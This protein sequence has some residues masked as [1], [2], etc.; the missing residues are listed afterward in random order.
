MPRVPRPP[1]FSL[2]WTTPP[3]LLRLLSGFLVACIWIAAPGGVFGF[4]LGAASKGL[5]SVAADPGVVPRWR[6]ALPQILAGGGVQQD[7][8]ACEDLR[9]RYGRACHS[10]V[11]VVREYGDDATLVEVGRQLANKLEQLR[12]R[13]R[14]TVA[15]IRRAADAGRSTEAGGEVTEQLS[16]QSGDHLAENDVVRF[17]VQE[18]GDWVSSIPGSLTVPAQ[19]LDALSLSDDVTSLQNTW[20]NPFAALQEGLGLASA[21]ALLKWFSDLRKEFLNQGHGSLFKLQSQCLDL[22]ARFYEA[23]CPGV[24]KMYDP[25]RDASHQV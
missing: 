12:S 25:E 20:K 23:G 16:R 14:E 9:Q 11:D 6:G 7:P 22:R 10:D 1:G 17:A 4:S 5:L 13:W 19:I 3:S 15:K 8:T 2:L 18:D 21:T 24:L